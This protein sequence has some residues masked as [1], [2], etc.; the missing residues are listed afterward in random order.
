MSQ[1]FDTI[2]GLKD[3]SLINENTYMLLMNAMKRDYDRG[4]IV[5]HSAT[6]AVQ[7]HIFDQES[8]QRLFSIGMC[9]INDEICIDETVTLSKLKQLA[10]ACKIKNFS[11]LPKHHL[12][13]LLKYNLNAIKTMFNLR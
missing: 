1:T 5:N 6:Q 7:P 11:K 9:R 2:E 12:F 3:D 4:R 13:L 8:I 10:R